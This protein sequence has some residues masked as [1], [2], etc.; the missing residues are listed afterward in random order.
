[1]LTSDGYALEYYRKRN[2][3]VINLP[4]TAR[5]A[6]NTI[7]QVRDR[8]VDVPTNE[9]MWLLALTKLIFE[10]DKDCD[11]RWHDRAEP[12]KEEP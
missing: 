6:T 2:Q 10:E 7:S 5:T 11:M 4:Q 9:L 8:K 3:I 1:M 12:P